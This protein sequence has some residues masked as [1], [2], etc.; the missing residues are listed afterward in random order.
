MVARVAAAANLPLFV[1]RGYAVS[2]VSLG[3]VR[4]GGTRW[5]R[6]GARATGRSASAT[7]CGSSVGRDLKAVTHVMACLGAQVVGREGRSGDAC[8]GGG[9][10][11]PSGDASAGGDE[12][13]WAVRGAGFMRR[14]GYFYLDS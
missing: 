1:M 4:A 3:V 8:V 2:L 14:E 13:G 5:P 11:G 6:G 9:R 12:A 7:S 10:V